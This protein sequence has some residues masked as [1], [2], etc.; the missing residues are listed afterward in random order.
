M[1]LAPP[2]IFSSVSISS[3]FETIVT[4]LFIFAVRNQLSKPYPISAHLGRCIRTT[5]FAFKGVTLIRNRSTE[6]PTCNGSIVMYVQNPISAISSITTNPFCCALSSR[7]SKCASHT[8]IRVVSR[9]DCDLKA[10]ISV[11]PRFTHHTNRLHE[12]C[13]A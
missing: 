11:L 2:T 1:K 5:F 13:V 7:N 12:S 8:N 4:L 3:D 6:I 9:G 10:G